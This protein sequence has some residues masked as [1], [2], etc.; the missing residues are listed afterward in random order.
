MR[1]DTP[2]SISS[3]IIVSTPSFSAE[4]AFIASIMREISPPEAIADSGFI[5]SP[6]FGDRMNST[7]SAPSA[8]GARGV[9]RTSNRVRP[10]PRSA[11]CSTSRR[12]SSAAASLR[13]SVSAAHASSSARFLSFSA[14][15]SSSRS[16]SDASSCFS[17]SPARRPNSITSFSSGP[18]LRFSFFI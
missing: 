2:V 16:S 13:A 4:M 10:M 15:F 1:P 18:Y 6:G 7:S 11:S 12:H 3:K 8:C 5:G 14:A 17:S 9:K